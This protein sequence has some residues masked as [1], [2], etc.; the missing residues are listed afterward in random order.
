MLLPSQCEGVPQLHRG[1]VRE[2][3]CLGQH[4]HLVLVGQVALD[5]LAVDEV[6]QDALDVSI[7]LLNALDLQRSLEQ[8]HRHLRG[9]G[10]VELRVYEGTLFEQPAV[11]CEL[12]LLQQQVG[13]CLHVRCLVRLQH[14]H[15][16]GHIPTA[17]RLLDV[18]VLLQLV[19]L[20]QRVTGQHTQQHLDRYEVPQNFPLVLC[21]VPV[22]HCICVAQVLVRCV[23]VLV[24]GS[25]ATRVV[26]ERHAVG[27]SGA[28]KDIVDLQR[29]IH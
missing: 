21:C 28:V 8:R 7:I 24:V 3:L 14:P 11:G 5:V 9:L 19:L 10:G 13:A 20:Q 29:H 2:G 18:P 12:Q 1:Q 4:H 16:Q 23:K 25:Q 6:G 22:A 27:C 17:Y 15:Q 26:P